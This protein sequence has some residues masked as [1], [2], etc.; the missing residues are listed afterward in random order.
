[1]REERGTAN[2]GGMKGGKGWRK[3]RGEMMK[4]VRKRDDR[5]KKKDRLMIENVFS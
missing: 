5:E 3:E 2:N 4:E 1:M